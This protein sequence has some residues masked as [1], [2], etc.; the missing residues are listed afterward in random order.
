MIMLLRFILT[1]YVTCL[2]Y[3]QLNIIIIIIIIQFILRLSDPR[4][5]L[6]PQDIEHVN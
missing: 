1:T 4:G 5:V 6:D 3:D 2:E